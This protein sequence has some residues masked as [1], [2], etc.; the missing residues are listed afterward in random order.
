MFVLAMEV[1]DNM[2][3]DRVAHDARSGAGLQTCVAGGVPCFT[4]SVGTCGEG[5]AGAHQKR[6]SARV[7][8]WVAWGCALLHE[9]YANQSV[10]EQGVVQTA[11]AEGL[12]EELEPLEDGLIRR[13]L[14]AGDW[15]SGG[16]SLWHRLLDFAVGEPGAR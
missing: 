12:R 4:C 14:H 5:P 13:C 1:L 9:Q 3:H 7:Q 8:D 2:P 6:S 10:S 11:G 15:A 16:K